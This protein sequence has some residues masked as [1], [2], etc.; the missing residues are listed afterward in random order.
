MGIQS[1]DPELHRDVGV[2]RPF[3]GIIRKRRLKPQVVERRGPQLP[4]DPVHIL[5]DPA[6]EVMRPLEAFPDTGRTLQVV[7][8]RLEAQHER[9]Q[10]LSHLIV[11]FAGEAASL[12]F[13]GGDKLAPQLGPGRFGPL[14]A[15]DLRLQRGIGFDQFH[16]PPLDPELQ[17]VT[18][19]AQ[20]LLR[21]PAIGNVAGDR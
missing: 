12:L 7:L 5:A 15:G 17:V 19:P 18:D 11:Q 20:L 21:L 1:R 16:R 8:E 2:F 4:G 3:L 6:H 13:L 10:M 9:G 14:P